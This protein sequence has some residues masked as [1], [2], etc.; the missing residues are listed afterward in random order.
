MIKIVAAG[1]GSGLLMAGFLRMIES[2]TGIKV[3][4]LLLNVDYVPLVKSVTGNEWVELAL[5]MVVA[6]AVSWF[7][8]QFVVRKIGS[9][10]KA[11]LAVTALSLLIGV[12][13]YP[14]TTLSE[15]TPAIADGEAWLWWLLAH[16]VY[17]WALAFLLLFDGAD[18]K[19]A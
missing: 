5:H 15:R 11:T 7:M 2:W 1:L 6:V 14:S 17:G 13:L 3:Y 19:G 16:L 9:Q 12:A 4:T 8:Y 10:T 18:K